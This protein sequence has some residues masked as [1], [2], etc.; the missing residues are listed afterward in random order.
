MS[1]TEFGV[2]KTTDLKEDGENIPVTN[3]NRKGSNHNRLH[4]YLSFLKD[5]LILL[6]NLHLSEE[7]WC[8]E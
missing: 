1:T 4:C 3:E 8:E 2:L 6:F 7:L 5:A